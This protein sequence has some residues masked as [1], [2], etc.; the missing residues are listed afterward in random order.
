MKDLAQYGTENYPIHPSGIRL[1]LTCPW[2]SAMLY[3]YGDDG[4]G[5]QAGDTGTA[6][7]VAAAEMHRGADTAACLRAMSSG[8]TKYPRADLQDAAAMF[9]SYATDSRNKN[10]KI[11]LIEAKIQ[12]QI[13][14]APEDPTQAPIQVTGTLDQVR[15]VNG[16]LKLFDIKTSKKDALLILH[17][18][19]FQAAAYCMGASILLGK[20]VEPG[21]VITPRKYA[22]K[23]PSTAP[24]FWHFPWTFDDVEQILNSVR[25]AIAN[26]RKGN[27]YHVPNADCEWCAAK[28]PDICLPKLQTELKLRKSAVQK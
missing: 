3:L 17:H 15:E 12:F 10:A 19:T 26:V 13:E 8:I 6:T 24:V 7:H 9:L 14:P 18:T 4:E 2:R 22:G 1:L 25:H 27:L 5:G 11:V 16:A 20:R 28:S 23:D 21:A